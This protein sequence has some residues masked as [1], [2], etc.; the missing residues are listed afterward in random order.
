MNRSS[1]NIPGK[2][3]RLLVLGLGLA[4]VATIGWAYY[5]SFKK[6]TEGIED[7]RVDELGKKLKT[8]SASS[9]K[10]IDAS[11]D[12]SRITSSDT[13]ASAATPPSQLSDTV[14][15]EKA[16]HTKIEE[17]DKRGKTLFKNKEV[18]SQ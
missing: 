7:G 2:E 13:T 5:Y 4:I 15:D 9:S 6:A 11:K 10:S 8:Q 14:V 17:M 16:L 1:S 12:S 3:D 18:G